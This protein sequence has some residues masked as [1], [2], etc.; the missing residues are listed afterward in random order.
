MAY[1]EFAEAIHQLNVPACFGIPG[2]GPSLEIINSLER[3]GIPFYLS[4]FE[5]SG[6]IMAAT[7]GRLSSTAGL[8]ISIKGPGLINSLPG[9]AVAWF[10]AFP[11]V[12]IA[13]STPMTAPPFVAHK[14]LPQRQLCTV[15][16][17]AT[18]YLSPD[19]MGIVE[20]MNVATA[21][22]PG[23]VLLEVGSGPA[24]V[25]REM[26]PLENGVPQYSEM[27]NCLKKCQKP[28][29][30]AGAY[31]VRQ[32]LGSVLS[33]LSVPIFTTVAA[34]GLIDESKDSSGGIF[35]GCR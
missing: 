5:G 17:K 7:I 34:K 10:E 12:H 33:T 19:G 31:A 21:E 16:T 11:L 20:A 18:G 25:C 32:G 35:H 14:R 29:V 24:P 6:V 23:P 26:H 28:I 4:H 30:I 9:L 3:A 1:Q 15:I 13:E 27:W 8:S 22:E 2:G